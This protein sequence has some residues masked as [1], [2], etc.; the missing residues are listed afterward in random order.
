MGR[1]PA[2]TI[3]GW[4]GSEVKRQENKDK[5]ETMRLL[6]ITRKYPPTK[7]GMEKVAYELYNHLAENEE[8]TLIK[9]GGSN[10][11]LPLV[12]PNILIR[13]FLILSTSKID[14]IYLQDGLLSPLGVISKIFRIPVMITIHGLDITYKNR[15]YQRIVSNSVRR[16]DKIICVS[17]ATKNECLK[18]EIPEEKLIVVP[19]GINNEF[20][21]ENKNNKEH[22]RDMLAEELNIDLDNKRILLSVGRLVERKGLHWFVE[23]VIPKIIGKKKD[24]IYLIAGDGTFKEK[25]KE[26]IYKNNLEKYVIIIGKIDDKRLKLIYNVADIFIM[27]NIRVKDNME[28][29]GVVALEA[30]SCG[31]PVVATDLEGIKDAIKNGENGFLVEPYNA[32]QFADII[33]KLLEKDHERESF[34]EAARKFTLQNYNWDNVTKIYLNEFKSSIMLR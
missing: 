28:G 8:V 19:N 22:L 14:V 27:P 20:N 13:M 29:F 2:R 16:L 1:L 21:I 30:A 3:T 7:G 12:L 34:G 4:D 32:G 23:N 25:I 33:T 15:L 6:Y 18:R 5:A 24:I 26:S 11:W 9:W 10:K 31:V 17:Q